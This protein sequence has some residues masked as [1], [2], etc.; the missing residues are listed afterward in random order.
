VIKR[1]AA[2]PGHAK[3]DAMLSNTVSRSIPHYD[4][5]V[6]DRIKAII[7]VKPESSIALLSSLACGVPSHHASTHTHTHTHTLAACGL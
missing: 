2:S 7:K 1:S 6:P 4:A 5:D 3:V